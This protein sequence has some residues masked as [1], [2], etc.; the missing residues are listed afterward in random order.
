MSDLGVMTTTNREALVIF[1]E[2]VDDL[3]DNVKALSVAMESQVAL[4]KQNAK[5]VEELSS[6]RKEIAV[7]TNALASRVLEQNK[8]LQEAMTKNT[9]QAVNIFAEKIA[10][11][12]E[13]KLNEL[14]IGIDAYQKQLLASLKDIDSPGADNTVM[15]EISKSQTQLTKE[16]RSLY[17]KNEEIFS[18]IKSSD[19]L[20][21]FP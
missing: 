1:A 17:K 7:A 12:F 18:K 9:E 14:S 15:Q 8:G 5:L 10:Q 11:T 2:N 6:L 13:K 3:K 19:G 16:I 20:I 21:K 4:E